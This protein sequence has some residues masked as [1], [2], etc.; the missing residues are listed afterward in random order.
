MI[1]NSGSGGGNVGGL[2]I[3]ASAVIPSITTSQ[4]I[5]FPVAAQAVIVNSAQTEYDP[6]Y[7]PGNMLGVLLLRGVTLNARGLDA[8]TFSLSEDG[9]RLTIE[10]ERNAEASAMYLALG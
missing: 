10:A 2:S 4:T 7:A 5:T 3:I 8:L 1:V 6:D 9:S